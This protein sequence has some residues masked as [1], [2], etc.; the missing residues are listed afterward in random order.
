MTEPL[1]ALTFITALRFHLSGKIKLGA[2]FASL[3]ILSR[4]EGFFIGIL[5]GVWL[6]FD[7]RAGVNLFQRIPTTLILATGGVIWILASW[8][9]TGDPLFIKHNWPS[10]WEAAGALYGTGTIF[11][12]VI[13]SPEIVGLFL[14]PPFIFGLVK[15][16]REKTLVTITSSFLVLFVLHTIFRKFGLFSSA[17]YPRYFVCVSP[18]VALLTLYGWN[19][20]SERLKF[21]NETSK[22]AFAASVILVSMLVCFLYNDAAS[23]NRDAEAIIDAHSHFNQSEHPISH[24]YWSHAF[25]GIVFDRDNSGQPLLSR[26]KE[27]NLEILK[28]APKGTLVFWDAILGPKYSDIKADEIIAVGYKNLYSQSYVLKGHFLRDWWNYKYGKPR[29]QEMYLLYKE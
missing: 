14:L 28:N 8:C 20:M 5:W 12:Y 23:W 21:K 3:L 27:Q 18:A 11:T 22:K 17:G 1:F 24:F 9:I 7:A 6:L 4:P 26:N 29:P 15:A 25:M 13:R 2:L 10:D 16:L 19:E